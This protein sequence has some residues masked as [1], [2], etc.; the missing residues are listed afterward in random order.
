M[1]AWGAYCEALYAQAILTGSVRVQ[2]KERTALHRH[3][4][5]AYAPET[6][7]A[8]PDSELPKRDGQ[9]GL[10]EAAF[11]SQRGVVGLFVR[12]KL[13]EW[14]NAKLDHSSPSLLLGIDRRH[15]ED[16]REEARIAL[17]S[18][19]WE[20]NPALPERLRLGFEFLATRTI[21]ASSVDCSSA[22]HKVELDATYER[23][24]DQHLR[25]LRQV[26]QLKL[27][28]QWMAVTQDRT[29][30]RPPHHRRLRRHLDGVV[31]YLG[32]HRH[33]APPR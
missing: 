13:L 2:A 3:L 5:G 4:G 10:T 18:L 12:Q 27:R 17:L 31:R 7:A 28:L 8:G 30:H 22:H 29:G 6:L 9:D 25:W 21:N 15:D 14:L 33:L 32:P 1:E 11:L 23:E 20:V 19:L 24:K 26:C 16:A